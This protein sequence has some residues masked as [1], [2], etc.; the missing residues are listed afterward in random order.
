MRVQMNEKIQILE[1]FK[2]LE[3]TQTADLES[4]QTADF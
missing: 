2:F 4:T 3:S 1:G